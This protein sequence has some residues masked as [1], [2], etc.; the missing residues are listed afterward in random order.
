[1]HPHRLLLWQDIAY[2]GGTRNRCTFPCE[3]GYNWGWQPTLASRCDAGVRTIEAI[4]AQC[5]EDATM[6]F[7][8]VLALGSVK[9]LP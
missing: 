3:K 4:K 5:I 8:E 6:A 9:I 2:A 1:M 7:I